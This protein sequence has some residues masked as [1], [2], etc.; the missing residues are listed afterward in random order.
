MSGIRPPCEVRCW[1]AIAPSQLPWSFDCV[2]PG[3]VFGSF[4]WSEG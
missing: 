4:F 3:R 2:G 1:G